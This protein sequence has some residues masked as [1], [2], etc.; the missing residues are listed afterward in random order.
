MRILQLGVGRVGRGLL[1]LVTTR[2]RL[3]QA[4]AGVELRHVGLLRRGLVTDGEIPEGIAPDE[5]DW[6]DGEPEEALERAAADGVDDLV[7]VDVSAAE[8]APL[9]RL[10]LSRGISV[11]T[12]NKVPLAGSLDDYRALE[13]TAA[14][15]GARLGAECTVGAALPMVGTLRRLHRVGDEVQRAS[16]ALSGTLGLLMGAV[17]AGQSLSKAV[18]EA[19][20][21]GFTEPDP[22][23][24]LGGMDVAR[25]ALILART[26]GRSLE[27][28]DVSVESLVPTS[29]RSGTVE[30]FF[31]GLAEHDAA[32]A[33][34]AG[35]ATANGATLRYLAEIDERGARVGLQSVPVDSA[36]GRLRGPDNR[37][38]LSSAR[39]VDVP[40]VIQGPG[41]GVTCTAE[42]LL[43]DVL[44]VMGAGATTPVAETGTR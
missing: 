29:L 9:L 35:E 20:A 13:E 34:R 41:A 31:T 19:H 6:R 23:E 33:D 7:F 40:L 37:L 3:L 8:T 25:K 27:P 16:G 5:L 42:G 17:T 10:A 32:F 24:D 39:H 12:A 2:R 38:E 26:L 15:T 4:R 22:R 21:G 30:D 44:E 43:E 14:S 18:R 36:F 1:D 28:G 11:V